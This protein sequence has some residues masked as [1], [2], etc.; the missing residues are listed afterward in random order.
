MSQLQNV[1]NDVRTGFTGMNIILRNLKPKDCPLLERLL[2]RITIFEKDDE[3]LA[4]ELVYHALGHADQK[5]Y[6]FL[7]AVD[8]DDCPVGYACF[9]PT[10]LTHGTFDLYWIAVDPAFAGQGVGTLLLA[11]VEEEVMKRKGRMLIIDTSS[12]PSYAMTRHFYLK[13]HYFLAETI[14]DYFRDGEDRVT[15][16]KKF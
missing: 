1:S 7:I 15:F 9:G 3:A 10:P 16:I 13:N 8:D 14:P 11:A 4:M 6:S 12:A 2:S 5:D